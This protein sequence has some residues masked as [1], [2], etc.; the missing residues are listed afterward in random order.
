MALDP[1]RQLRDRRP[2]DGRRVKARLIDLFLLLGAGF[3]LGF[4]VGDPGAPWYLVLLAME[5]SYFFI[6]EATVGYT[7]GKYRMGLRVIRPDGTPPNA[8][9]IAA[10]NVIRIVEEP[11]LALL[12][13]AGSGGR[14]QR[15]GDL[16]GTTAVGSVVYSE[17]PERTAGLYVYPTLW[18]AAAIAYGVLLVSPHEHYLSQVNTV[19]RQHTSRIL[20]VS[21][22]SFPLV[23]RANAEHADAQAA[24]D[25]PAS[26][27]DLKRE[28]VDTLR[29]ANEPGVQAVRAY[30]SRK[31]TRQQFLG[32]L[33]TYEAAWRSAVPHLHS[34]GLTCRFTA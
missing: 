33:R 27:E 26:D 34:L 17:P 30:Q 10:R 12:V 2:L 21:G 25:A 6:C 22:P 8:N 11:V 4:L 24:L 28:I 23:V 13:M 31:L 5:V 29:A 19:C 9:A 18:I 3:V 14:R 16:I 15:L 32:Y 1:G 7:Y 20:A